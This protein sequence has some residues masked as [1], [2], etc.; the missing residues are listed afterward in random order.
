MIF[1]SNDPE[2]QEKL[3]KLNDFRGVLI[4]RGTVFTKKEF[5]EALRAIGLPSND[6]F[7][8]A[9]RDCVCTEHGDKVFTQVDLGKYV[10]MN[11]NKPISFSDVQEIL[12]TYSDI[13]RKNKASRKKECKQASPLQDVAPET[14]TFSP[15]I[16]HA[17]SVLL[18]HGF[19][20]EI[21]V[22]KQ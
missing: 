10:F 19:K 7:W 2:A 21:P 13:L 17:I 16:V 15:E 14:V 20:V 1:S 6:F 4:R 22:S 18:A 5:K 3:Y 11:P 9:L 8:A 12:D